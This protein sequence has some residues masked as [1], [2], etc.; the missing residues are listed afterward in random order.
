MPEAAQVSRFD[1]RSDYRRA[2]DAVLTAARKDICVFDTDLKGVDFD[3]R[4]RAEALAAFLSGDRDRSLRIV[5]HDTEHVF[6]DC[7]RIM[8]L[9][10]RFSHCFSIR[11]TPDSLRQLADCFIV[12]DGASA[13]IRFHADHSRGKLLLSLPEDARGWQQRFEDLWLESVPAVSATRLG[14]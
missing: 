3:A 9:L 2:V 14:L 4:N 6:R 11:Q 8:S 10:K 12:A 13:V 1:S 7:P 5:L